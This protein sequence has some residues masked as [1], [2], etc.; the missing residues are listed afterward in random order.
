MHAQPQEH[1]TQLGE[2]SGPNHSASCPLTMH[3]ESST[4]LDE[5]DCRV[6]WVDLDMLP[7]AQASANEEVQS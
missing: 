5:L 2:E 1:V 4:G 7:T 6:S 3:L